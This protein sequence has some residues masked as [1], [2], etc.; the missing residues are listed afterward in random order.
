MEKSEKL[1][2]IKKMN[3]NRYMRNVSMLSKCQTKILILF[4]S[5]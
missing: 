1:P 4:I 3:Y 2:E 5:E